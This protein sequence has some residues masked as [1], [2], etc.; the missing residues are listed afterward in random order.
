MCFTNVCCECSA[1]CQHD[2]YREIMCFTNVCCECSARCQ[3]DNFRTI[4][5]RD[6]NAANTQAKHDA[7]PT[8]FYN[9]FG[10]VME[11]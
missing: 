2:N 6:G 5:V 8:A 3:H 1:R 9:V 7:S 10:D 4:M 11:Q